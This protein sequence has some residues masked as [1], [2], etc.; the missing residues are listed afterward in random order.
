MNSVLIREATANDIPSI[1]QLWIEAID[2][3]AKFD[4]YYARSEDG[5]LVFEEF[6]RS[7]IAFETAIVAIAESNKHVVG[8]CLGVQLERPQW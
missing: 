6:I 3:A 2:Y 1:V 5:H 4:V 7:H 8:Y